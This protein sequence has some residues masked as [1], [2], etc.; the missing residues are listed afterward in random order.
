MLPL[1]FQLLVAM[2]AHA[3][4]ARMARSLH[5]LQEEIRVVEEANSSR[6]RR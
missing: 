4:N 1:S 3:I 2:V 5:Y 6:H